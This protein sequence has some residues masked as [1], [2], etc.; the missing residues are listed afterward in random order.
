METLAPKC[1]IAQRLSMWEK[2]KP[3]RGVSRESKG[4]MVCML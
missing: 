4:V 3:R 1:C 2:R